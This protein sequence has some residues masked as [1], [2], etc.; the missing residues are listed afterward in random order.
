MVSFFVGILKM[1]NENDEY[2]NKQTNKQSKT[3]FTP[4]HFIGLVSGLCGKILPHAFTLGRQM[5]L[6]LVR[7]KSDCCVRWK[8]QIHFSCVSYYWCSTG[9][10]FELI[11]S[12]SCQ[13][14]LKSPPQVG[15][16]RR[17]LAILISLCSQ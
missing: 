8:R 2:T 3:L 10:C 5:H 15:G 4:G 14:R 16:G 7:M 12:F 6:Q 9:R 17:V 11:L 1:H 13:M